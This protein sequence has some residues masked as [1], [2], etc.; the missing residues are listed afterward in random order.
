MSANP[1]PDMTTKLR[2][3]VRNCALRLERQIERCL[4]HKDDAARV[5]ALSDLESLE[6]YCQFV[7]VPS[8]APYCNEIRLL[9]N[10]LF[11]DLSLDQAKV[12][13]KL[14]CLSILRVTAICRCI[15]GAQEDT[16]RP[17]VNTVFIDEL[18]IANGKKALVALTDSKEIRGGSDR[19]ICIREARDNALSCLLGAVTNAT[20]LLNTI[21][22]KEAKAVLDS[23]PELRNALIDIDSIARVLSLDNSSALYSL[24]PIVSDC[25]QNVAC[26]LVM[27]ELSLM[28]ARQRN[29]SSAASATNQH[30]DLVEFKVALS[31][32]RLVEILNEKLK[33]IIEHNGTV[34]NHNAAH[35]S[36]SSD[37]DTII[38][39][40]TNTLLVSRTVL[41]VLDNFS[42]YRRCKLVVKE[43][44]V[45]EKFFRNVLTLWKIISRNAGDGCPDRGLMIC[46]LEVCL[47]QFARAERALAQCLE[48]H[49]SETDGSGCEKSG[50]ETEIAKAIDRRCEKLQSDL[51]QCVALSLQLHDVSKPI[52]ECISNESDAHLVHLSKCL[53]AWT[54]Q[55][56]IHYIGESVCT[57]LYKLS[58]TL[59]LSNQMRIFQTVICLHGIFTMAF[60]RQSRAERYLVVIIE[61]V[62]EILRDADTYLKLSDTGQTQKL[63]VLDDMIS[64]VVASQSAEEARAMLP[65]SVIE[66]PA[67]GLPIYLARSIRK[68]LVAPAAL[69]ECLLSDGSFEA[70]SRQLVL[71]LRT[72][73]TG[74][75]E[76][77]VYRI[78]RLSSVLA[79]VHQHL[80]STA[81]VAGDEMPVDLL[82]LAHESLRSGLNQAA[83]RQE[84]GN[85]REVVASLYQWLEDNSNLHGSFDYPLHFAREAE[86]IMSRLELNSTCFLC[87]D[88]SNEM[89]IES[90]AS[91]LRDLH[92]L[93]GSARFFDCDRI[94]TLCHR[95]E[96]L[97]IAEGE[98]ATASLM[99]AEYAEVDRYVTGSEIDSG[100]VNWKS[101]FAEIF[102]EMRAAVDALTDVTWRKTSGT[103]APESGPQA[104]PVIPVEGGSVTIP[105]QALQRIAELA[106]LS[107]TLIR[108]SRDVLHALRNGNDIAELTLLAEL[109]DEQDR[110]ADQLY[111]EIDGSKTVSFARVC[112]RLHRL[113]GRFANQLDKQVQLNIHNADL[114]MD[115][116]LVERLVAPLEHL[117]RNAID[118]GIENVPVR[119]ARGKPDAG[120]I[121]LSI[122]PGTEGELR[123]EVND[124]G[125]GIDTAGLLPCAMRLGITNAASVAP[126]DRLQ[127]LLRS[128]FST[129]TEISEE[130][131]HGI[132]LAAVSNIVTTLGGR[133]ELHSTIRRG[134][135]FRLVIPT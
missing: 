85:P 49:E 2:D 84:V 34:Q 63:R 129:R 99:V 39:V 13:T 92:T 100:S 33:D 98:A 20:A 1:A 126:E 47:R 103:L 124:D 97:L 104:L 118:H 60:E 112:P 51:W 135:C 31:H 48:I 45:I 3:S 83:A 69:Q 18:R 80:A 11:D 46:T 50:F 117:L 27:L 70:L 132:G 128:G 57:S 93:K 108:S 82:M 61:C 74:A 76:L 54:L 6:G 30:D 29:N 78:E 121:T 64:C 88:S 119:R 114:R 79:E 109:L 96:T 52:I 130:S 4:P 134:S 10:S 26:A 44:R 37:G 17:E 127:W 43:F 68:L 102:G 106:S 15:A 16:D 12:G 116:I 58:M 133:L 19:A 107:R 24:F 7:G 91:M 123:I 125:N 87:A 86:E 113:A 32:R 71:E 94:A 28:H 110:Y 35:V 21:S 5:R 14:L 41:L 22:A 105:A 53:K 72:L 9:L 77:R 111:E 25:P 56:G 36:S 120:L 101:I 122:A 23:V 65:V 38:R 75:R 95:C 73:A 8:V 67:A 55:P 81:T 66:Q 89:C 42:P 90:N 40:A 115:R 131:G 62:V 59:L